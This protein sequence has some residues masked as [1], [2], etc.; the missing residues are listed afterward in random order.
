MEAVNS[1]PLV[2]VSRLVL[3]RT[4][5]E[6]IFRDVT[7]RR[8]VNVVT[9]DEAAGDGRGPL[10][11]GHGVGKT[12][13]CRLLR[14]CLGE[15]TFGRRAFR[16][17]VAGRLPEARVGAE[18]HVAG[19]RWAVCRRLGGGAAAR[20]DTP[21]DDLLDA[22]PDPDGFAA[23]LAALHAAGEAALPTVAGDGAGGPGE[24]WLRLL[25]WCARDQE[26]RYQSTWEWR[27]ARS[28]AET[29]AFQR[30]KLD[31]IGLMAR[32]MGLRTSEEVGLYHLLAEAEA[33]VQAADDRLRE[34]QAGYDAEIDRARR[35]LEQ[36]GVAGATGAPFV[37]TDL[38]Q[39]AL[40][41]LVTARQDEIRV[42]EAGHRRR[43][44]EIGRELATIGAMIHEARQFVEESERVVRVTLA[45]SEAMADEVRALEEDLEQLRRMALTFCRYGGVSLGNCDHVR[46]RLDGA[47][48]ARAAA[49]NEAAR[50]TSRRDQDVAGQ[51]AVLRR[52]GERV[53]EA[54]RRQA[55]LLQEQ[56]EVATRVA[57]VAQQRPGVER[58][59]ADCR[60]WHGRRTGAS[61]DPAY[62]TARTERD[63]AQQER[64][65]LR[66][67]LD[68]AG[69]AAAG[70]RRRLAGV[71]RTVLHHVLT[72]EYDGQVDADEENLEFRITRGSQVAGEAVD[73]L[74]V[75]LADLT[76]AHARSV[77]AGSHPGLVIHDSPREADL[78]LT[79]YR[80][81]LLGV[82][83]LAGGEEAPFQ[84]VVTTTTPPPDELRACVRL[85]LH[86]RDDAGLLFGCDLGR[87]PGV[88]E[89]AEPAG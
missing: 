69:L 43:L 9:A 11:I 24:R 40:P 72:E 65:R 4:P 77:G 59:W 39:T 49:R 38:F 78:G 70:R 13:F 86:H 23:Y 15:P 1:E 7:L 83:A 61:P 18:V 71:F 34:L 67:A 50:T 87:E 6:G 56:E 88:F 5:R 33:R 31:A 60:L 36:L 44:G 85:S 2:W 12:S 21:V 79:L 14:H 80:R 63:D 17:R 76:A 81:L 54:E 22:P 28:E 29:P 51:Q 52:V 27:A 48:R 62:Q 84:Y 3:V 8:G 73:T 89:V 10:E 68:A 55:A 19:T 58:A 16:T 82:A 37:A 45:G 42:E 53:A 74:C 75:L 35:A 66:T 57:G 64:S 47:D 32:V 46:G 20:R 41:D 25:A 26:T 30:R